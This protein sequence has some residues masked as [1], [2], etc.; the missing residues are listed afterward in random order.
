MGFPLSDLKPDSVLI[1]PP[2]I[3]LFEYWIFQKRNKIID[4]M[5]DELSQV[6]K[7]LPEEQSAKGQPKKQL[8]YKDIAAS[9][10]LAKEASWKNQ[11][12]SSDNDRE[13]RFISHM[14]NQ[15]KFVLS[16][17]PPFDVKREVLE[18][19]KPH[20][21]TWIAFETSSIAK[22]LFKYLDD[23]DSNLINQIMGFEEDSPKSEPLSV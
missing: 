1:V 15:V 7:E 23:R 4:Q 10:I 17:L 2:S 14:V 18:H 16:T 12:A 20:D 6:I 13:N 8:T 21:E 22:N 3:E 5:V 19:M 9:L 11:P